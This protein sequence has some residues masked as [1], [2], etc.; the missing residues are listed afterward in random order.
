MRLRIL[1]SDSNDSTRYPM[2]HYSKNV[3]NIKICLKL[4]TGEMQ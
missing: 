3:G 2:H 1:F 4:P